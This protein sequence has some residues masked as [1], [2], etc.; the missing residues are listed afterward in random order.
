[1]NIAIIGTGKV[2][3]ALASGWVNKDHQVTFGSRDPAG[4]KAQAA[5]AATGGKAAV[6]REQ[7]AVQGAEVVV[8]AVPWEAT[9]T[10]VKGLGDLA[11]KVLIDATN[12]IGPGFQLAVG[13]DS[14]GAEL[15]QSWAPAARVVKAFNSTGAENMRNPIYD[16]E[17]T[18]MFICGDE[19]AAKT[20]V[21][22]LA[23]DLGFAVADSGALTTARYLEPLAMV[24]IHLAIVQKQ[25]RNIAFKVVQR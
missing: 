10:V 25:G 14:S 16:G 8:L 17:P 3:Q 7:E 11:G 9:E 2:G 13:K 4:E 18:T 21:K 23:E 24:W 5:V 22:R 15:V 20:M 1:M 19:A 12:P 6:Q